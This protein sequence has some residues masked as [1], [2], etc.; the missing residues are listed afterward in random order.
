MAKVIEGIGFVL[1]PEEASAVYRALQEGSEELERLQNSVYY[2]VDK[3]RERLNELE[4]AEDDLERTEKYCERLKAQV[5]EYHDRLVNV[6]GELFELHKEH[7][8]RCEDISYLKALLIS[9]GDW[10]A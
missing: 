9:R 2:W 10:E 4:E 1:S 6:S 5:E 3:N 8:N 7:E